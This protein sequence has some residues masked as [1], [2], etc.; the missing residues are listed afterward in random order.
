MKRIGLCVALLFVPLCSFGWGEKGH[1]LSSEA[2]TFGLPTDMPIFFY[3][4]YPELI[5]LGPDPDRWRG[6]GESSDGVNPPDHFL[7]YETVSHF[8][9]PPNRYKFIALLADSGT[10]RRYGINVES[11]GFL[12]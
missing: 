6:A 5:Y 11:A 4:S 2:A 7:D 8:D 9:L 1:L 10:L 3:K 12:P